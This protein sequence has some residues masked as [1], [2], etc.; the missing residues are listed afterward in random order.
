MEVI[1]DY[2]KIFLASITS[3]I[4]TPDSKFLIVSDENGNLNQYNIA[5][6]KL[7]KKYHKIFPGAILTMAAT[8]DSKFLYIAGHSG[9]CHKIDLAT[10][11]LV[12][13]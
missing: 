13:N 9:L 8:P 11:N 12:Q 7:H 3:L 5:S 2:G 4:C 10:G 1:K 6:Y